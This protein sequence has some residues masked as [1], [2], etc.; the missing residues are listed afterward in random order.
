MVNERAVDH[1]ML[2]ELFSTPFIDILQMTKFI[3]SKTCAGKMNP[4]ITGAAQIK[5]WLLAGRAV[6]N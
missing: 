4:G 6:E 5:S 1:R 2:K 3:V